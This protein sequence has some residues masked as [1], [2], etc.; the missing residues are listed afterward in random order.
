[1]KFLSLVLL[2]GAL[3]IIQ[4]Y[5]FSLLGVVPN[6]ALVAVVV[7][8]FFIA[9]FFEGIF[10][11]LLSALILKFSSGF[12]IELLIFTLIGL[13]AVALAKLIPWHYFVG[14]LMAV[15]IAILLFYVFLDPALILSLTFIKELFLDIVASLAIFAFL[16][17]LWQ[18]R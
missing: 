5:G 10:L 13:S 7:S 9:N 18:D 17:F 6:L 1:M 8:A 2:I 11:V 16:Y 3:S 4:S 14:S 15:I 12:E